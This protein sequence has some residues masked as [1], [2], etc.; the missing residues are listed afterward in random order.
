MR[1]RNKNLDLFLTFLKIGFFTFG[2]GVAMIPLIEEEVINRKKYL[3]DDEFVTTFAMVQS[4]PGAIAINMA[5]A[6]GSQINGISGAVACY[7]GVILPSFLCIYTIARFFTPYME[8]P[9]IKA[10]FKGLKPA[11]VALILV[12]AWRMKK[13]VLK[14]RFSIVIGL[15]VISLI[16]FMGIDP[17][18]LLLASGTASYLLLK[19]KMNDYD[20]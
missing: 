2:G 12:S 4:M 7:F 20:S 10:F 14:D 5:G 16:L 17:I 9:V 15:L 13:F 6:I 18:L 1:L 3:T 19:G 8:H 11:V